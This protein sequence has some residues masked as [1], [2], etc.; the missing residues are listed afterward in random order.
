MLTTSLAAGVDIVCAVA[1]LLPTVIDITAVTANSVVVICLLFN[2]GQVFYRFCL[3]S[4]LSAKRDRL[5][6]SKDNAKNIIPSA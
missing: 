1:T 6:I 3:R 5:R 4:L 2:V